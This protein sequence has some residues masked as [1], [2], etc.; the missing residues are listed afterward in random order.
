VLKL[1]FLNCLHVNIVL[2]AGVA[3]FICFIVLNAISFDQ[4][5]VLPYSS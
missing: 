5:I 2:L 1:L 4:F 3:E